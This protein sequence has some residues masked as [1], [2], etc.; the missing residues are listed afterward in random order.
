MVKANFNDWHNNS[1]FWNINV[2]Y[3]LSYFINFC[4]NFFEKIAINNNDS[5]LEFSNIP[6]TK[7]HI[8]AVFNI[9]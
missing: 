1:S 3:I 2:D 7:N 9:L 5:A 4:N 6:I 8:N